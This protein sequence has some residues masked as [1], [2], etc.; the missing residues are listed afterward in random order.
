MADW[1]G[2]T[3]AALYEGRDLKPTTQ[4]D[5]FIAGAVAE[6]FAVDPARAMTALFPASAKV[7]AIN[8]LI[9]A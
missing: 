5:A 8:G 9:R 7:A 3:Q 6:H 2:L 1:P 4:L